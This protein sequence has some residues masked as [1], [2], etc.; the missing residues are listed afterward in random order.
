[1]DVFNVPGE[2]GFISDE[3]LPESPLP[4]IRFTFFA[5]RWISADRSL[6]LPVAG[7]VAFNQPPAGWVV[8][9][10]WRQ[11]PDEMHVFWQDDAGDDDEEHSG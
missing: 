1:M 3:V 2:I 5:A 11:G 6:G 8:A 7:E 10:V 4:D 9:F